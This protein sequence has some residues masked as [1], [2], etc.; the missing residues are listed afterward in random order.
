MGTRS[1][2]FLTES[3]LFQHD[4]LDN[5]FENVEESVLRKAL[6][7]YREFC[8]QNTATLRNEV[9]KTQLTVFPGLRRSTDL[10]S[11]TQSAF[12][13]DQYLLDDPL[14]SLSFPDRR[15][16][17]VLNRHIGMPPRG[18]IRR[19]VAGAAR[20]MKRHVPFVAANYVKFL[21]LTQ[22]RDPKVPIVY[23]DTF[24]S[25]VLPKTLMQFFHDRVQ[26]RALAPTPEGFQVLDKPLSPTRRIC[27]TLGD[28]FQDSKV[29]ILQKV[30]HTNYE[31]D[32]GRIEGIFCIPDE[33]PDR[34]EFDAWVFQ[35][36]NQSARS[37]YL[38]LQQDATIAVDWGAQYITTTRL[39]FELLQE[40]LPQQD[41]LRA[42]RQIPI[43]LTVIEDIDPTTLMRIR[44]EESKAFKSFRDNLNCRLAKLRAA[45]DLDS[46]EKGAR[47]VLRELKEEAEALT[48]V[49][50]NLKK[51]SFWDFTMATCAFATAVQSNVPTVAAVLYALLQGART[52]DEYRTQSRMPPAFF[53]W[54]LQKHHSSHH[55]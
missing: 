19:A 10:K 3:L 45:P 42:T 31:E 32:T 52:W 9:A 4:H 38:E 39:D 18:E 15:M 33:P 34:P 41:T 29:Y 30:E 17:S 24:F 1:F 22:P 49:I 43:D 37:R 44:H 7:E 48:S 14:Y 27:V 20:Y 53:L 13:L 11:I 40:V 26:V 55:D 25:D 5:N 12:Y 16:D 46:L 54:K 51:K 28:D 23:S 2:D 35:S 50:H 47:E 36:I 21:P 8:D 6:N